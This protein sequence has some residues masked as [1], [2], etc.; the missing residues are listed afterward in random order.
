MTKENR[1]LTDFINNRMQRMQYTFSK[2]EALEETNMT[3]NSFKVAASRLKRG[4]KLIRPRGSFYVIVPPQYQRR[5]APPANLF[6]DDL[7]NFLDKTYYVG[8]LSAAAT[9]GAAHQMPQEYQVLIKKQIKNIVIKNL[10]VV[11]IQN[12]HLE[13]M[14]VTEINTEYSQIT[15]S[16]PEATAIDLVYYDHRSGYLD[17]VATVLKDLSEK[18]SPEELLTAT[19]NYHNLASVQRLGYILDSIGEKELCEPIHEWISTQTPSRVPLSTQET[20]RDGA[21]D[22]K[23]EVIVN[24]ELNPD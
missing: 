8:L 2:E 22:R 14:P 16:T 21:R 17:N 7:M 10:R 6:I 23:W 9:F 19:K 13:E 15:V 4:N 12:K 24:Y 1:T 20:K 11:F 3:N 18:M 5:G